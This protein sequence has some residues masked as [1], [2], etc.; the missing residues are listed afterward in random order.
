MENTANRG[1]HSMR[2]VHRNPKNQPIGC[3]SN[4][5]KPNNDYLNEH[6]NHLETFIN[7]VK[8]MAAG[9]KNPDDVIWY[10]ELCLEK[11]ELLATDKSFREHFNQA[12]SQ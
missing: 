6:I 12:A 7:R 11:I 9:N 8:D 3:F 10:G 5:P 2:I 4:L 1:T